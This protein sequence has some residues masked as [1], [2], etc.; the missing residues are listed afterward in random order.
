ME[1]M[2][3]ASVCGRLVA[4]GADLI[5]FLLWTVCSQDKLAQ[6]PSVM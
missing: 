2:N 1:D 6:R 4:V 3:G 5:I